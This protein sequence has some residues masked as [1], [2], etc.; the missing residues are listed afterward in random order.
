MQNISRGDRQGVQTINQKHFFLKQRISVI[1]LSVTIAGSFVPFGT[2]VQTRAQQSLRGTTEN[3]GCALKR[4]SYF[5][6]TG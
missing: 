6:P 5:G 3:A 2:T 4:A 1:P